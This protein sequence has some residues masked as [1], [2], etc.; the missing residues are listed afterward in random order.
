MFY[1]AFGMN[2]NR[3]SMARRCPGAICMG[4][5]KL[6]DHEFRFAIHADVVPVT[7]QQVHGV[8]WLI[9]T[10]HLRSLDQLEGYPHYY[11]RDI[12]PVEYQGNIVMAECYRMQP[13]NPDDYPGK[14]YLDML[15]EGYEEHHVPQDQ[16]EAALD[17]VAK[18]QQDFVVKYPQKFGSFL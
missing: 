4:Y 13:D 6:Q 11:D 16:I 1:F 17:N 2:T 15:L 10:D 7:D 3:D 14:T 5:A 18:K 9:D 8:L 12:L